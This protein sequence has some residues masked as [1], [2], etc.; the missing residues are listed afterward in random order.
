M[1]CIFDGRPSSGLSAGDV[2]TAITAQ[3]ALP[4]SAN[5][6]Q[7]RQDGHFTLTRD[8]DGKVIAETPAPGP[9]ILRGSTSLAGL[10]LAQF[11]AGWAFGNG[12]SL[13]VLVPL[14]TGPRLLSWCVF[15]DS[16]VATVNAN[17]AA[18]QALMET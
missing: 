9:Q 1:L 10:T 17:F 16:L 11:P 2:Q 13:A 15:P 18:L 5:T 3:V 8:A 6:Y 4:E 12:V 7:E 14:S